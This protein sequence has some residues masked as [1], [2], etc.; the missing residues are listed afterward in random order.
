MILSAN[1]VPSAWRENVVKAFP[2]KIQHFGSL[3]TLCKEPSKTTAV[4]HLTWLRVK[5]KIPVKLEFLLKLAISKDR[6]SREV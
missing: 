2:A 6:C 4:R 3:C 1:P 5:V